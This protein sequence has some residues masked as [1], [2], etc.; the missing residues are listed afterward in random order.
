M[1]KKLIKPDVIIFDIDGV[2]VDVSRSYRLAIKQTVE[3]FTNNKLPIEE[4]Q[5][6]ERN[7][8]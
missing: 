4:V 6:K 2:L 8:T 1:K 3:H 7:E 5:M